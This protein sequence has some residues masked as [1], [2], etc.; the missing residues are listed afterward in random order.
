MS[1]SPLAE[2]ALDCV[3][4]CRSAAVLAGFTRLEHL[5]IDGPW[6][7]RGLKEKE[8]RGLLRTLARL[9]CLEYSTINRRMGQEIVAAFPA[10]AA[11][12][13]GATA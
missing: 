5:V 1:P 2:L 8:V 11:L 7:G 3:A 4:A 6:E 10:L 9:P 12:M 13:P